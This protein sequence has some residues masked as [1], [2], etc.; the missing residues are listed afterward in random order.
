MLLLILASAS[1]F[2]ELSAAVLSVVVT[3]TGTERRDCFD[4][5]ITNDKLVE[6]NENFQL[7]LR[8]LPGSTQSGVVFQPNRA[9]VTI[10]DDGKYL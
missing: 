9:S 4:V 10:V 5:T 6:Q 1:D 7:E 2:T 3:F 8:S